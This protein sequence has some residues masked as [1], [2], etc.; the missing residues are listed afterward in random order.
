VG[1]PRSIGARGVDSGRP[2]EDIS[3]Y[4]QSSHLADRYRGSDRG[5]VAAIRHLRSDAMKDEIGGVLGIG[6]FLFTSVV[7][8]VF[9]DVAHAARLTASMK[10]SKSSRL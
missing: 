10:R 9:G 4:V 2:V 6:A 7:I 8:I 5:T 3:R 1:S